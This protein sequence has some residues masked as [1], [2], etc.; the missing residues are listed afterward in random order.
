MRILVTGGAGYIGSVVAGELLE[1]GHEVLVF[2]NLSRGYR[3]AV[4]KH[5]ELIVGDLADRSSL[6]QVF[7][8][9]TIDAVMHFAALIEAGESMKAPEWFFRNNTPPALR[10]L[11]LFQCRRCCWSRSRRSASTRDTSYSQDSAG[12]SWTSGPC[13]YLR[14]RLPHARRHLCSR[15]YSRK[16][17]CA[18]P[19]AGAACAGE[20]LR[21]FRSP[22]LQSRQRTGLQ[23]AR[24]GRSSAGSYRPRHSCNRIA[25]SRGRSGSADCELGKNSSQP[26]LA[27]EIP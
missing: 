19:L 1:A 17:S 2:D 4:P 20:S 15:L 27:T 18:R 16:R 9:R 21:E 14:Y 11:T 6:E 8:S 24:G 12:R 5:A 25:S 7:R 10:E 3:Q 26:R 13:Q 22:H 23:C